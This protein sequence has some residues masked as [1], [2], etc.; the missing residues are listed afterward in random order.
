M[1][2]GTIGTLLLLLLATS[3]GGGF[4]AMEIFTDENTKIAATMA[5]TILDLSMTTP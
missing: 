1:S 5:V 2:N 3:K 4:F